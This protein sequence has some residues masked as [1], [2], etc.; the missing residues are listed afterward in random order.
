[1]GTLNTELLIVLLLLIFEQFNIL[2]YKFL[3]TLIAD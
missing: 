1:M 2:D 3:D